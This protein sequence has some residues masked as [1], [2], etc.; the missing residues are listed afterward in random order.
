MLHV[1]GV[2]TELPKEQPMNDT[3]TSGASNAVYV[4]TNMTPNEVIAFRRSDDGSLDRVGSV[5]QQV[6][7]SELAALGRKPQ[8][9]RA[10]V[11]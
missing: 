11:R 3:P 4:Q 5:A 10:G 6:E 9:I 7:N 8:D 1:P 2:T